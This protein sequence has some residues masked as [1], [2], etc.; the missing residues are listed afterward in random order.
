[1]PQLKLKKV[2]QPSD[3]ARSGHDARAADGR[4]AVAEV[5]AASDW[6]TGDE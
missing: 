6:S 1:M 2:V 3:N 4:H 5:G